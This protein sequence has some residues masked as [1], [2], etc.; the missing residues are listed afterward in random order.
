LAGL[1]LGELS[2][3][4]LTVAERTGVARDGDDIWPAE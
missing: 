1:F 2:F 4:R 3:P